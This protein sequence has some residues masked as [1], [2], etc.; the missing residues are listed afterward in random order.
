M[1]AAHAAS[2]LA[3]RLRGV[4]VNVRRDLEVSR[5]LFR[6]KP[7]YII[8]D[9]YTFQCHRFDLEDYEVLVRIDDR[10][11]LGELFEQLV[12]DDLATSEQEERFYQFVFSLHRLGFLQLP[13]PDDKALYR[14]FEARQK[15]R[16]ALR[17]LKL[18]YAQVPLVNP[19]AFLNRH[20][21]RVAWLFSGVFF[22]MWLALVA[23][24]S[25]VALANWREL[26]QPLNGALAARNLPLMWLTLV[27]LKFFHEMGHA[28]A[29]KRFGG[30]VPEMGAYFIMFTPCAY[31]DATASWGFT[32][33]RERLIVALAGM[34]IESIFAAVA[35]FVWAMTQPSLLNSVAYNVIF[36][37]SG[38]T[39]LFN[40]N[41]L[42]RY[43]G[44]YI[45]SDLLELPNLRQRA[46][47]AAADFFC[48]VALGIRKRTA[49]CGR[50]LEAF[51]V[52]FGAA[53]GAFRL[54]F[55][56]GIATLIASRL[57]LPGLILAAVFFGTTAVGLARRFFGYLWFAEETRPVRARAV[58]VSAV[59]FAALTATLGLVPVRGWISA[60]GVV[61]AER[62]SVLHARSP[63]FL[64]EIHVQGGERV[65]AGQ[66]IVRLEN[67]ELGDQISET[68][69]RIEAASIRADALRKDD[70]TLAAREQ[71]QVELLTSKRAAQAAD[72]AGLEVR[73]ETAGC[74]AACY[75]SDITGRFVARGEPVATVVSG[76]TQVRALL[77]EGDLAAA[78]PRL[79]AEA[80][81]RFR[82][83]PGEVF[84]GVVTRIQPVGSRQ[85]QQP[86]LANTGGGQIA[87][88]PSSGAAAQS[89]FELTID[90]PDVA[91]NSLALGSTGVVQVASRYEP[92]ATLLYRS[93]LRFV[94]RALQS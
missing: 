15:S 47:T 13:I 10:R 64:R 65:F 24:A 38:V 35:V 68:D 16:T 50:L 66:A 20:V 73:A 33:R 52:G 80:A 70:P 1:N 78:A 58:A 77:T 26:V 34:Y 44:Y 90:L 6:G 75:P 63:G 53:G 22:W 12:A 91:A 48:R 71:Q 41:P 14:R 23:V 57:H 28:F 4:C 3:P 19:D 89:Y 86:A 18:L 32:R 2:D 30:H 92:L 9:P 54:S 67:P 85:I 51:L 31:V 60:T 29:C 46:A 59:L 79:G 40:I 5:H 37:A 36:L 62:E 42:M 43:D 74:I 76:R 94:N 88:D 17:P 7:A 21:Q 45:L 49:A 72:F 69:S 11:S 84:R 61:H 87:V 8:R 39:L 56:L 25:A 83:Q 82:T 55:V 27:G 81:F 93:A